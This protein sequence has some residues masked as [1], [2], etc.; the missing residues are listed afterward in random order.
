MFKV[1]Y[2]YSA[3]IKIITDDTRILCDPWFSGSAYEGTWHQFPPIKDKIRLTG[4]FDFIYISHIHP[5]HYCSET[6]K[7]LLTH[8]GNKKILLA[9]WGE[10]PN[11]LARKMASDGFWDILL[12]SNEM[13][14]G[15]TSIRIIPNHT[16]SLSDID[17]ALIVSRRKSRRAVLNVNDCIYNDRFYNQINAVKAEGGL[18]FTL[19]CLGYTGAGSYPQTYYSPITD[20]KS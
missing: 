14:I 6:I 18:E 8:Y 11:Y 4:D 10:H 19:F 7:E 3:C 17:S 9:D 2:K 15:D 16:G 1:E 20:E 5:D 13:I 12:L